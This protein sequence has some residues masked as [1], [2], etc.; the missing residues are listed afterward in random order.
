MSSESSIK[1]V[2]REAAKEPGPLLAASWPR[3]YEARNPAQAWIGV[4]H[5]VSSVSSPQTCY[6]F[7]QRSITSYYRLGMAGPHAHATAEE[8]G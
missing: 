6:H 7:I 3:P 4:Q 1:D 2:D 8:Y 5:F